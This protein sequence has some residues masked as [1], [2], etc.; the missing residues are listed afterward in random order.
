MAAMTWVWLGALV[1]VVALDLALASYLSRI[2]QRVRS[3]I[4]ARNERMQGV[5]KDKADAAATATTP[6]S[7]GGGRVDGAPVLTPPRPHA[8]VASSDLRA[9]PAPH[10]S[11]SS[12]PGGLFATP[13]RRRAVSL[14]S[15]KFAVAGP[16]AAASAAAATAEYND[17]ARSD[18]DDDE[19]TPLRLRDANTPER[20][21]QRQAPQPHGVGTRDVVV[22]MRYDERSACD[23]EHY[24][25][26]YDDE[27]Y[28]ADGEEAHTHH[29]PGAA[30]A[31]APALSRQTI[32]YNTLHAHASSAR[33]VDDLDATVGSSVD[34]EGPVSRHHQPHHHH[35]HH[36]LPATPDAQRQP[37]TAGAAA[38]LVPTNDA[39]GGAGGGGRRVHIVSPRPCDMVSPSVLDSTPRRTSASPA[40]AATYSPLSAA[41]GAAALPLA[42]P[43]SAVLSPYS[44][45]PG[46]PPPPPLP[47][48]PERTL[49]ATMMDLS[50]TP[51][52]GMRATATA[53]SAAATAAAAA[54]APL[55]RTEMP[56]DGDGEDEE[57]DW[58][59][60][61]TR[62]AQVGVNLFREGPA[63]AP[64]AATVQ[65]PQQ[66]S[67]PHNPL[68]RLDANDR[69]LQ[70]GVPN[71]VR[72][73]PVKRATS[74]AAAAAADGS[75]ADGRGPHI[76]K[77][78]AS[79]ASVPSSAAVVGGMRS[80]PSPSQ[81][82]FTGRTFRIGP[83]IGVPQV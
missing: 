46:T 81:S 34:D 44:I 62:A 49:D 35:H 27:A 50:V 8:S 75:G 10:P 7:V 63:S 24:G 59:V 40:S 39:G 82:P 70:A 64:V 57:E 55:D 14:S 67:V 3:V 78:L 66:G 29:A 47:E 41:H 9:L 36:R 74:T 4:A 30:A 28:G 25:G 77:L 20:H 12:Q 15:D 73:N 6:P 33:V 51:E 1:V 60:S 48:T 18:D 26:V 68:R 83:S 45:S 16:A 19:V 43:P 80:T 72:L 11:P 53:A 69:R 5:E 32:T 31:A 2:W 23:G 56:D 65:Q 17:D 54:P 71:V 42:P 61:P 37:P 76:T 58:W 79:T 22:Q 52:T 21:A 38:L 13:E